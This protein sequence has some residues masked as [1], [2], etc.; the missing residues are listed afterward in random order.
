MLLTFGSVPS[1]GMY[2]TVSDNYCRSNLEAAE[3][4]LHVQQEGH[5]PHF[6]MQ[7]SVISNL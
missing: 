5:V 1:F 4:L 7:W 2:R 3:L 6:E